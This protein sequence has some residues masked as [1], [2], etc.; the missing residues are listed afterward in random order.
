[1]AGSGQG[2]KND[3]EFKIIT[4]CGSAQFKEKFWEAAQ[5][6]ME[7]EYLVLTPNFLHGI[8]SDKLTEELRKYFDEHH[9]KKI[10]ISDAILVINYDGYIGEHTKSEIEY[11]KTQGKAVYYR[12]ITCDNDC[13]AI[14]NCVA[15]RM[16]PCTVIK[17]DDGGKICPFYSPEDK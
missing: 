14:T 13:Y 5:E 15:K 11:A 2:K 8:D 16:L 10:D 7:R 4:L 9:R 12:Y 17:K 6:L 3:L 1:M